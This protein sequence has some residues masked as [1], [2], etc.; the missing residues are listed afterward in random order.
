MPS[1]DAFPACSTCTYGRRSD[2][3]C[4]I[5]GTA[6]TNSL[7]CRAYRGAGE[8]HRDARGTYPLLEK[9]RPGRVYSI[10]TDKASAG[11]V[12]SARFNIEPILREEPTP[13][14]GDTVVHTYSVRVRNIDGFE[15]PGRVD[16]YESGLVILAMADIRYGSMSLGDV[17]HD[18]QEI[19]R[20]MEVDGRIPL[21][22]GSNRHAL[23][24]GMAIS[25]GE[26]YVVYLVSTE[27]SREGNFTAE[28]F[29]TD[30]VTE[31]PR[32]C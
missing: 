3:L 28:T 19:R 13:R 9:L 7:V 2:G 29:G 6:A 5:H 23:V 1:V 15:S 8:S 21:V 17:F 31:S 32:L 16:C 18:F 27:Q 10:G 30:H 24:S 25:M 22:N 14:V 26:G 12:V 4:D 20:Q 11:Q